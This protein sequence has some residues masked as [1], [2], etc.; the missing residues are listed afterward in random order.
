MPLVYAEL[1]RTAARCL[2][3]ERPGHTL[4]PTALVNEAFLRM[5]GRANPS[6]SDRAHF[7]ALASQMMRRILVDYARERG[8]EKRGG[9]AHRVNTITNLE[10][11]IDESNP[12]RL[13]E[14]DLA[15]E[16]L[17]LESPQLAQAIELR[18]FG[19][20]TAEESAEITGRSVHSVRHDLR[21]A[22]AWLRRR[23]AGE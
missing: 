21:F 16:A 7:L 11:P 2:R 8:A 3:R 22:H 4:Q 17:A 19:G 12:L 9:H 13:L 18:Y 5:F 23:L 14:L 6:V 10:I 15:I 1:R 20:A